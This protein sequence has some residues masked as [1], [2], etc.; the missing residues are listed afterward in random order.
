MFSVLHKNFGS[1]YVTELHGIGQLFCQGH[2]RLTRA[3]FNGTIWGPG[4]ILFI[5]WY[6]QR[7]GISVLKFVY[8]K[9][10]LLWRSDLFYLVRMASVSYVG[11]IAVYHTQI[12]RLGLC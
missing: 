10:L 8:V 11:D 1:L 12:L 2:Y 9:A 5:D 4:F 7:F 6:E 3:L